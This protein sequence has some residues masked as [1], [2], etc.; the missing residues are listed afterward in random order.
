MKL[1]TFFFAYLMFWVTP[2]FAQKLEPFQLYTKNGTKVSYKTLVRDCSRQDVVLFGEF[3]NNSIVHWLQLQLMKDLSQK[4]ALIFGLEMFERDQQMVLNQYLN[5]EIN[6]KRF[7]TITRFWN[8]YKTDYHP[9]V[10]FA[11][12][13]NIPV[14]A[15]NVPRKYASLLYKQ[16]EESLMKLSDDE[17]QWI[18]PLPFPYDA[19]LPAYQEMLKMFDDPT[20]AN[21]NFPKAQAIKDATM[22]YSITENWKQGQLFYH[23]QGSYHSNNYE[24]I[25]WYLKKYNSNLKVLTISV[26]E[27]ED[28]SKFNKEDKNLADYIFYIPS[29][30]IKTY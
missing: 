5:N 3:H 6:Q 27:V 25:F 18:A 22:A 14:I 2:F 21:P 1:N 7:D 19:S 23:I 10:S 8:N 9:M 11:K 29:D 28:V 15:T 4:R 16:G 13:K 26:V 17:K 30:M 24:G 20:H 12:D